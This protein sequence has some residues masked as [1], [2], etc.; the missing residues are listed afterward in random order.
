MS[1]C[2]N[3]FLSAWRIILE[4]HCWRN[5]PLIC[6][7]Y[8]VKR[9]VSVFSILG[10]LTRKEVSLSTH[11][12]WFWFIRQFSNR[13]YLQYDTAFGLISVVYALCWKLNSVILVILFNL[14]EALDASTMV[15]EQFRG[16]G[17]HYFAMV[18]GHVKN[19]AEYFD[20]WVINFWS[21]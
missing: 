9:A 17:D 14:S 20:I 5:L 12:K 21:P 15:W 13:F 11:I 19:D 8:A 10:K 6:R 3:V 18:L 2:L 7:K 4:D 16:L 1:L